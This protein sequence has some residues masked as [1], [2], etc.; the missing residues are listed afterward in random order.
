MQTAELTSL[1]EL[2]QIHGL[3]PARIRTLV[4]GLGSPEAV[5]GASVE[6]MCRLEG[7]DLKLAQLISRY[8]PSR[9]AEEQMK[10]SENEGC[11]IVSFLDDTYP[12]HLKK[13]YDPPVLLFVRGAFDEADLDAVSIVGTRM[14]SAYGKQVAQELARELASSGLT[15]VSGFAKGIDTV[16]HGG[17][18]AVGGRTVAV[19]GN[20]LDIVY[21]A[22]NRKM[23]AHVENNGAIVSEFAFG[24]KPDAGNFPRRNRIISGLSHAT[25]VVEA[26]HRSGAILTALNAVDQNRDVFAVPGRLTDPKSV[27][28]NRL[29][30]NGAI[31]VRDAQQ[32]LEVLNP[33]L[34]SPA[35][36]VQRQLKLE[37]TEP[38][39]AVYSVLSGDPKYVDDIVAQTELDPSTVLTI[40]L[41][42]ELKGA[43][44]QLSGKQFTRT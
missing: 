42:L 8:R 34:H 9:F 23:I 4:A 35:R 15:V 26:G 24:T 6:E 39:M 22:A 11:T 5:L 30:R 27:G 32:I 33:R 14:P 28:C 40:L 43:V 41:G 13:I 1:L 44:T 20:G 16:A 38:E 7:I 25:V 3:G 29:I 19:L 12:A 21:P 36:P 17:A 37:L 31:P 18:L 10:K 2:T